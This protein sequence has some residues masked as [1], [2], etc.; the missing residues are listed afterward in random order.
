MGTGD[1]SSHLT[2]LTPNTEY[3][4]RAYATNS[5]GTGYGN[6]QT[7]KTNKIG[8]PVLT[9][10]D[11]TSVLETSALSGGNI[12]D[13]SGAAVTARGVCWSLTVNPTTAGSKSSDGTG[14]GIFSSLITGLTAN[15][16]Y[17]VRAYAKNSF[18]TA[19]GNQFSFTTNQVT[20]L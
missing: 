5:G 16:T 20:P 1:Y 8:L 18:G 17:Y 13:D 4:V 12:T 14:T 2:V 10:K 6:Q 19:Y 7:F 9:T 11:L 15:T 3:F